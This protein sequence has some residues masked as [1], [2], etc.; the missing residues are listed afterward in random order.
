MTLVVAN[1]AFYSM[2]LFGAGAI[3]AGML[4]ARCDAEPAAAVAISVSK[5]LKWLAVGILVGVVFI[6]LGHPGG[7][8]VAT[9]FGTVLGFFAI[10]F[11]AVSGILGEGGDFKPI[12]WFLLFGTVFLGA[13]CA[14]T[15]TAL[16]LTGMG[17]DT[18][19]VFIIATL[20]C[21]VGFLGIRTT[22]KL[23]RP[24]GI[25][26]I[27]TGVDCLYIAIRYLFATVGIGSF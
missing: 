23:M 4:F 11:F 16:G 19:I 5:Y 25:L 12:A 13:Y 10:F 6:F 24:A 9:W 1:T 21:L 18:L 20:A 26:F 2:L 7:A 22:P 27:L 17:L 15:P 14:M 3:L 8:V